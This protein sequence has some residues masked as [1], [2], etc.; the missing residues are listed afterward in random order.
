MNNRE[1]ST[2]PTA[3][4]I[5]SS[6]KP[7][8]IVKS[9]EELR[10]MYEEQDRAREALKQRIGIVNVAVDLIREGREEK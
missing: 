8:L 7:P 5:K 9:K 2:T 1:M 10:K 3:G 6:P 4:R